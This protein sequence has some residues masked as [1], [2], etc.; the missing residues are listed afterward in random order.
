MGPDSDRKGMAGGSY[1][2]PRDAT[3]KA[4]AKDFLGRLF[5]REGYDYATAEAATAAYLEE[6]AD[7]L[8]WR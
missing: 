4:D 1:V 5:R 2:P 7:L 3:A 8:T 6:L